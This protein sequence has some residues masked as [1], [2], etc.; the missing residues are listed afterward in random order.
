MTVSVPRA[1]EVREVPVDAPWLWLALGW[2]DLWRRP[3]I[4]LAW[5]LVFALVSAALTAGLW[6]LGL[7][8]LL[9]PLAAGFAL[10]GPML[11]VGLYEASRHH[12]AGLPVSL[13]EVIVVSTRSPAALAFLGVVLM[14]FMLAWIRIATLLFAL[15]FGL[16]FPPPADAIQALLLTPQGL[17]FLVSGTAIGAAL[18]FTVYCLTAV[19]VPMLLERDLD[20]VTAMSVSVRAVIRNFWPMMLWAWLIALLTAIGIATCYIGMIVLFPLLG[21][22]TWHAYRAT[23]APD[24]QRE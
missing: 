21:H 22:A 8:E 13:G 24:G 18:A 7:L 12:E 23:V 1:P 4:S 20:V 2:R 6:W 9:L 3:D 17:A 15:F 5:G 10:V 16:G 11:A 14:L 19:S